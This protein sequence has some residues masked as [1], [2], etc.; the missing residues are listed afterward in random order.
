[1]YWML[2]PWKRYADFRGRSRRKEYWMFALL[3]VIV[4]LVLGVIVFGTGA[5]MAN[6]AS[7]GPANPFAVYAILFR[8]SGLLFLLWW[9][10]VLIPGLALAVRRFHDRDMSGWWLVGFVIAN[11]IPLVNFV[12]AIVFLVLMLLPGTAGPN[13]FGP[14]PKDSSGAEVFS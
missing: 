10:I 4:Y 12:S 6:L 5:S 14:D 9:L 2:L 7:T 11:F 13:R 1:M 3:N 8:G